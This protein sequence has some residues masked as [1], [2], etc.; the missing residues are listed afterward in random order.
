[1]RWE[2]NVFS[3]FYGDTVKKATVSTPEPE[4]RKRLLQMPLE[5]ASHIYEEAITTQKH[6]LKTVTLNVSPQ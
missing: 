6:I 2:K 1:M 5:E 3:E 4:H